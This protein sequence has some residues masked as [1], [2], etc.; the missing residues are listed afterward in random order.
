MGTFIDNFSHL[1]KTFLIYLAYLSL[2][3]DQKYGA[4]SENQTH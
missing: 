2:A 3:Q 1:C 4:L